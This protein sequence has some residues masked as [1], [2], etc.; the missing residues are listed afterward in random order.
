MPNRLPHPLI[1]A[2]VASALAAHPAVAAPLPAGSTAVLSGA[3]SLADT[4]PSPVGRSR[5]TADAVSGD[6]QAVVFSSSSDGLLDGDDDDVENVYVKDGPSGPVRL[7]S[8]A[9]GAA[10]EPAHAACSAGAISDDATRVAFVCEGPLDP[11]DTNDQVDVYIRDL[12]TDETILAS[13]SGTGAVGDAPSFDPALSADGRYVAFAS[14]AKNLDPDAPNGPLLVFR[15]DTVDGITTLV[16]RPSAGAAPM[17]GEEPSIDDDG[18]RIAFTSNTDAVAGDNN[19]VRDVYLRSVGATTTTL[20]SRADGDGAA[21]NGPS[22]APSLDGSGSAVAFESQASTFDSAADGDARPDVYRRAI[23]AKTT[24][25]VSENAAGDKGQ[26]SQAPSIDRSGNR[27]AFRSEGGQLVPDDAASGA[28]AYIKD[29]GTNE[30]VVV[31]RGNGLDGTVSNAVGLNAVA[32]SAGGGR[33]AF[34]LDDG[35]IVPDVDGRQPTVAL[36]DVTAG[37]TTAI[38]RPA[39]ADPFRNEGGAATP[40]A[41]SDDG[42]FAAF[43][44]EA[45][46]LGLPSG[47]ARGVFVRD[48]VTGD[49]VLASR[50]DGPAGAAILPDRVTP[51]ISGDGRRV[52][53]SVSDGPDRGVWVRDLPTGTSFLASR[54]DGPAGAPGNGRSADPALDADGGRVVFTSQASN[55]GDGDTNTDSDV[56]VRDL[57]AGRTA[58]ASSSAAGEPGDEPSFDGD[59]DAAGTRV[60]FRTYATN[61][62]DGDTDTLI[63]VHRKDLTSGAI[64]LVSATPDG[65]KGDGSAVG[66]SIDRSGDR[67]AFATTTTDLPG[68]GT[69]TTKVLVRDLAA[70]TLV[71]ASRADGADGAPAAT[72]ADGPVISP[73]G[74]AVGFSSAAPGLAPGTPDVPGGAYHLYVRALGAGTTT[75]VSRR[76]GTDAPVASTPTLGDLSEGARCVA[77]GTSDPAAGALVRSRQSFLRVLSADC[78]PGSGGGPGGGGGPDGGGGPGGPGGP[79][80]PGGPGGDGSDAVP[81]RTAPRLSRVRLRRPVLRIA[82]GRATA[83]KPSVLSF[84]SSEPG[85][86]RLRITRVKP[87]RR[88][89][90]TRRAAVRLGGNRVR[91]TGRVGSRRLPAGRYRLRLTVRDAA[92]NTSKP[93]VRRLTVIRRRAR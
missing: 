74:G 61:L 3:P 62:G 38:A 53:W 55:L 48:R 45:P 23:P 68:D 90:A 1:L 50:N 10:G 60:V 15:R 65:T 58:L 5:L 20:V 2:A 30:L 35:L 79:D 76:N 41:L 4:L 22:Y 64:Q 67:V 70:G 21:G 71:L 87:A 82:R 52:A 83:R 56:H 66:V 88:R 6:G 11:A 7:V 28:D 9:T 72:D 75:L 92:G 16:S 89:M 84:R 43:V 59:I 36:R 85:R 13:R 34:G 80:G 44:S 39:G 32:I 81:D 57:A 24:R 49:V 26:V 40:A 27:I 33:V 19:G 77:F 12:V 91:L 31:S 18:D 51:A 25:L 46:G 37:F 42:R 47:V 63:D 86:L 73:D 29:V 14:L 69:T 17:Q 78:R 93:V 8:R 54:A